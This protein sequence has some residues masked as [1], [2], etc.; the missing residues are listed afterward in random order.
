M[1]KVFHTDDEFS[2]KPGHIT[3]ETIYIVH[4]LCSLTDKE[5]E[6][7]KWCYLVNYFLTTM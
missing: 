6:C 1:S 2:D 7:L 4:T 3:T 5:W